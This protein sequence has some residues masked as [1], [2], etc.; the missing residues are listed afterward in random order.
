[1]TNEITWY[2]NTYKYFLRAKTELVPI[3]LSELINFANNI[4]IVGTIEEFLEVMQEIDFV[5]I[6]HFK[7]IAKQEKEKEEAKIKI[8]G[9]KANG[10]PNRNSH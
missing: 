10:R 1:M 6:K 4:D 3:P 7:N 9:R 8:K 2:L 5:Y